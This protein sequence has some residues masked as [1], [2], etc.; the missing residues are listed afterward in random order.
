MGFFAR[1]QKFQA[2]QFKA[3]LL[4]E[5]VV[6]KLDP[7]DLGRRAPGLRK[8]I[9]ELLEEIDPEDELEDFL[10][11]VK[12]EDPRDVCEIPECQLDQLIAEWW[13]EQVEENPVPS[14]ARAE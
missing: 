5:R 12:D 3:L 4:L 8:S 11:W 1:F 10:A 14:G 6:Q 9:V 2:Q 13:A 7:E